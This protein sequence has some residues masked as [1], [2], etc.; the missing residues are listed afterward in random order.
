VT[1]DSAL[2]RIDQ[3]L[4]ASLER[5]FAFIRIPSVSTDPA[6]AAECVRC[7]EWLAEDL[8]SIGFEATVRP[9]PG[10][11]MV[12]GHYRG[13][14]PDKPTVLF[15]GHYD[16]QPVDP[17]ALWHTPPFEPSLK[18]MP[19]GS[20]RILGRGAA[21]DKGQL[22]TF[23]EACRAIM[24]EAGALP[25]N[26]TV[27]SEGE[28]E[29]GSPS[30]VPFLEAHRD[31][32]AG[33]LAL[34]CDTNMWTP[35]TPAIVTMLRG[36]VGEEIIVECADQDLHS[37]M[38]GGAAWNPIHVLARV[39]SAIHDAEGR[40]TIPGFYDGVGDIPA[41]LRANWD[42]LGFDEAAFLGAVGLSDPAGE[43]GRT[44]LEKVWARPTAEVNGIDGG[45]IG[46]GFKTVLPSR[47]R[48]KVSFRLVGAQDPAAIRAAFRDFVRDRLPKDARVEFRAHGGSPAIR[49]NVDNPALQRGAAA[50]AD[51]WATATAM[52]G[53]GGSIPV[54]GYLKDIVGL[55]SLMVGFGLAD[56]RIHSPNEKYDLR[57]FHKGARSWA[58]ILYALAA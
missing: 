56:D 39:L 46:D 8:R 44:V 52:I 25:V 51:E 45:Y 48:A 40:V 4:D 55:D 9:T 30:L 5:L 18:S 10:R 20:Q 58:R 50:L 22:M 33:D 17:L 54:V 13:A 31:E 19:D 11:P 34:V 6:Y 21:D 32:L 1:L 26:V 3:D 36:L 38:F 28:E 47:A 12:V 41:A 43:R 23:V 7:A 29:S 24:A 57:S 49:L 2:S 16:V 27:L 15:Y 14:G 37:G 42:G 35:R 53:S